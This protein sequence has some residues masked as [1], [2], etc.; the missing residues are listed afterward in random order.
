[1]QEE[2]RCRV[3]VQAH[4]S[5][6]R[7]KFRGT[8]RI[9]DSGLAALRGGSK[10]PFVSIGTEHIADARVVTALE[11][12]ASYFRP[13]SGSVLRVETTDAAGGAVVGIVLPTDMAERWAAHLHPRG[14]A[15]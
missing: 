12:R 2:R 11:G 7:R 1:M 9:T 14:V 3:F 5:V 6:V 13:F 15:S 10:P 8:V 4:D